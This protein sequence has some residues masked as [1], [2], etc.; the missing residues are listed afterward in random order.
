MERS[1][2][3]IDRFVD[4][5]AEYKAY[6]KKANISGDNLTGLCP[7]HA[8]KN[9]SFSVD[10]KTGKWHCLTEDTG[11]NFISFY[12][13]IHNI[14]NK[15]A[16]K[17]ILEKYGV[18]LPEKSQEK[19][20][21]LSSYSLAQYALEKRLPKEWLTKEC[22]LSTERDRYHKADFL[23]IPY[24]NEEGKEVTFRKRFAHK[25]F[26][27]KRKDKKQEGEK[28][29]IRLYGEWKLPSIREIGYT[30][31]VEGESDSQSLWYMGLSALGVPG[32]SMFKT[33]CCALLQD[34]KLYIH[35]EKDAGGETF[36]RKVKQKLREGNF[37]GEVCCFTCGNIP[38]C[39]DPSDVFLKFGKEEGA[40][41]IVKL[42][43]KAE[44]I[45]LDAP[46]DVSSAIE[47][48]PVALR[49][50]R[51][52]EY[53]E[54]GISKVNEK[55]YT[56]KLVCR[57]PL[58]LTR[59]LKSLDTGDE[60][61]EVAFKRDQKWHK[62]IFQRSVLFTSRGV[63]ALADLG[64]TISSENARQ[65]VQFLSALEAENID[66]IPKADSTSTFGWQTG[67]RFIPGLEEGI[68]LDVEQS[69]KAMAAAYVRNGSMD[70]C[71]ETMRPHRKRDKFRFILS[72]AFTAPLLRILRQRT[73][74]VYN[75]GNSKAGKTAALKAALSV[76]GEP[77]QLMV[78]FNATQVGLERTAALYRD[79]PL[80]IDERQLA[81]K[82]QGKIENI[83][84]MVANE[85]GKIRGAK[86]GGVQHTY[87]WRTV[88]IAT[89]EEPIATETSKA[90]VKTRALEVYGGPF[91]DEASA[92]AMHQDSPQ[93]C[94]WAGPA[95]VKKLVGYS[96]ESICEWYEQMKD[97]VNDLS[98]GKSGSHVSAIA[99]VALADALVEEWI[100]CA[101]GQQE[102][103]QE[104]GQ[105]LEVQPEPWSRARKMAK[106]ILEEQ[107]AS[108]IGDDNENAVQFL[109]DWVVS[110]KSSFGEKV[111]GPCFG[112]MSELGDV[113]Y[114]F[115]SIFRNALKQAGYTSPQK[116]L[117]YMAEKGLIASKSRKDHEG[118]DYRVSCRFNG[119]PH[120]FYKFFIG[121]LFENEELKEHVE[122]SS[123][124]EENEQMIIDGFLKL[125][126]DTELPFD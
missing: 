19:K 66:V 45:D 72:A 110:N 75:W 11:G 76:W 77:E 48:A 3:D 10:L 112:I 23:K 87:A 54:N 109:A 95:F 79:L 106:V 70:G 64:C 22:S 98:D 111:V 30:I 52:W 34:L 44:E 61:I 83:I 93:N 28:S 21:A 55:S 88:A 7:F 71:M 24:L 40:K 15:E 14:D 118:K 5:R 49:Q 42:L 32:A 8:E 46:E 53:S 39:K 99:A 103:P 26:R 13:Q 20:G 2:I 31:L 16:F 41:K 18:S 123:H 78:N 115:P 107:M 81:G 36:L 17:Q 43:Q 33:E 113:A 63:T 6:V 56:T 4:Y 116:V 104:K 101:E 65:V 117:K 84:Y 68:L 74:F 38:D 114:I 82:D 37:T 67:G 58:L 94:G 90:G 27:W 69:Q 119:R 50:P 108:D 125:P 25:Q 60:K 92:S 86:S 51:G 1:E 96:E 73:F 105:S 97:Y 35:K 57:T 47:D 100:F 120:K 59:R 80:G 29:P 121:K 89:G 124:E 62:A 102:T 12:A 91:E 126:E 85:K 9:P 122:D